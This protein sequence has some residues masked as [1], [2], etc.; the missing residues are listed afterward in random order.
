[1]SPE[2]PEALLVA[3]R[4][5]EMLEELDLSYHLGGSF[6]SS[7]HGIPRQTQ[8]IDFVVDLPLPKV[9][10]L[11]RLAEVEFYV[12]EQAAI[13]AVAHRSSFNL[14]HLQSAIKVDL[15]I[16]GTGDFDRS[17]FER[18]SA[19]ILVVDPRRVIV[20][21][22][23]EDIVLRK[24]HWYRLGGESSERQ[25]LDVV[26]LLSTQGS[27]LDQEYLGHW[28]TVLEV[29]DLLRRALRAAV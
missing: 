6:A 27:A 16:K 10:D 8:D 12:A 25:W 11:C 9:V 19:Q 4:V 22:S 7:I 3:V 5:V 20:V 28:A 15:F 26:G 21:K 29:K 2:Q 23:A 24:L 18:H 1:M 17:E 13:D 14:I